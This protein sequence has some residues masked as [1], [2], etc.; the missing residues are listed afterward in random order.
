MSV[1]TADEAGD[2]PERE[3]TAEADPEAELAEVV[4]AE[5]APESAAAE[6]GGPMAASLDVRQCP[7]HGKSVGPSSLFF[8]LDPRGWV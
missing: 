4:P 8:Y 6:L 2:E 5:P 1:G 3:A 7:C